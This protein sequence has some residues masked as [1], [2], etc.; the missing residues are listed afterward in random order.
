MNICHDTCFR[1]VGILQETILQ[2][3]SLFILIGVGFFSG[4]VGIL[5]LSADESINKLVMK[6]TFP[7]LIVSNLDMS[8]T[9]NKLVTSLTIMGIA[10][11]C[12]VTII[13]IYTIWSHFSKMGPKQLGLYQFLMI[14]GNTSFMGYPVVQAVMGEDGVFFAAMFNM[15]HN[16]ICYSYGIFLLQ[17]D[18]KINLKKIF[19]NVLFL[20]T[21]VGFCIFLLPITLPRF[22]H[23]PMATLGSI[24]IPL[25]L[26]VLGNTLSRTRFRDLIKPI[27]VW[28]LSLSRLILFPVI[29]L[30]TLYLLGFRGFAL[31]IPV[32]L[33]ATPIAMSTG[34]VVDEYGGDQ[35][36]SNKSVLLSN[37]LS[38][39]TL[40]PL[41]FLLKMIS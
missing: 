6:L 2:F 28:Y 31:N 18:T 29:L 13:I 3:V 30:P 20:S 21:L 8:F 35:I 23:E 5:S 25:C 19:T 34:T 9:S 24:T 37:F 33:F 7:A 1:G 11:G 40:I 41:I 38:I 26:L 36:F 16:F 14:F 10:V 22:I 12:Y 17:K 27:S 4:K 39:F 15:V 32:I